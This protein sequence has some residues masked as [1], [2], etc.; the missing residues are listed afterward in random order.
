MSEKILWTEKGVKIT[1]EGEE[2]LI[3][4]KAYLD[5]NYSQGRELD[6]DAL[7]YASA[8]YYGLEKAEGYLLRGMRTRR[9]LEAYLVSHGF[10]EVAERILDFMEEAGLLNDLEYARSYYEQQR[11][12]KGSHAIRHKLKE[13]GIDPALLNQVEMEED[14]EDLVEILLKKYTF[15][16]D[17]DYKEEIKRKNFLLG[18]GF[19]HEAINKAIKHVKNLKSEDK[20]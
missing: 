2:Y 6:R 8:Y 16:E 9:Q 10:E 1:I 18:R 3:H 20:D 5:G 11:R 14:P 12:Q 7:L 13:R 4:A 15:W 17:I 19:S